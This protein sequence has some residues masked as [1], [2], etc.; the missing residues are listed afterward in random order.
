MKRSP[1][2]RAA[3]VFPGIYQAFDE[4]YEMRDIVLDILLMCKFISMMYAYF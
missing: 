2:R 4:T 1:P 3:A